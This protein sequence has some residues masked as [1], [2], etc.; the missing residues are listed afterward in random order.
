M[1]KSILS[2]I[3]LLMLTLSL[4]VAAQ[5]SLLFDTGTPTTGP[6]VDLISP[7]F[8]SVYQAGRFTLAQAATITA[9]QGHMWTY[10]GY[11]GIVNAVIYGDKLVGNDYFP[12]GVVY[13]TG[14]FSATPSSSWQGASGLNWNFGAGTYWLAFQPEGNFFG[15]MY[16]NV[17]TPLSG[18]AVKYGQDWVAA[19]GSLG[20]R[21]EGN[22]GPTPDPVPEPSTYALFCIG[23]GMFGYA[24]KR[25][26]KV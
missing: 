16:K 11:N 20:F 18:Y 24:R 19:D 25:M 9:V 8:E 22:S 6:G 10:H 3:T 5:A 23:L 4:A 14:S 2:I 13:Q 17:P 1:K 7:S 21:I 15:G 12:D 26:N